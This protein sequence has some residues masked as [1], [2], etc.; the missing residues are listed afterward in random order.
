MRSPLHVSWSDLLLLLLLL[1]LATLTFAQYAPE[2]YPGGH[3]TLRNPYRS[4]AFDSTE[5]QN[6]AIQDLVCDHSLAPGWYRFKLNNKPAE[7]PTTCVEMNRCGTQ[8]PVWLSLKD[9]SLP[10]PGEVLQL[11]ACATWQFFHG[12][13]KDC[14]L[15]RIPITIRNCGDFLIYYLQPTQGCMGYC[16]Q[17]APTLPPRFCLPG[18]VEIN[19]RCK[20]VLP[21]LLS[22]PLISSELIG[23][24]VH[25]R[26]SFIPPPSNE[27]L[28]F[29][30]VWARHI[31]SS[32]K[33]EIR[34]ESTLKHFS[35]VEMDGLHFRLGETYSCSVS[36]FQVNVTSS[37]SSPRESEAFYAGL[38]FSVES[39]HIAENGEE[40]E[41]KVHST[42]P[43]SCYDVNQCGIP[44]VLGVHDSDGL[45]HEVPNVVVSTCQVLLR[46]T[47]CSE[48]SCGQASFFVT[49]VTDFTRDGNRISLISSLPENGAPQLWRSYIPKSLKVTV[50]DVPTSICYSLTDPHVITLDGR[51]YDNQQTGTF[52]LYRSLV[53]EFEV[54]SRQWDCGSRHHTVACSCGVAAREGNGVA[55]IDMCNGQLQE[56]RPKI[57]VKVLGGEHGNG[58]RLRVLDYHQGKKVT[59]IFPSG[60]FVRAD[61]GDWGMSL[62]IRAPSVD[63]GNTQGLC[64]TFDHNI[65]NDIHGYKGVHDDLHA[66]IEDWRI[67]PGESLF[68]KMPPG[69]RSEENRPFCRCQKGYSSFRGAAGN[70]ADPSILT[71]C[72]AQD[73]VDDTNLFPSL[74]TTLEYIKSPE[75]EGNI[76]NMS[77]SQYFVGRASHYNA[78]NDEDFRDDQRL[79]DDRMRRQTMFKM[80]PASQSI[81]QADL[82][83]LAYFF[84][85]DHL[86]KRRPEVQPRWPTPSGLSSGKALEVCHVVLSNST[87]G[88]VCR[89]LL[90]RRLEEAVNLCMLDLQLKDDLAW[91]DAMLPYLENECERRLLDNRAQ[92]DHGMLSHLGDVVKALQCPNYCNGNGECTEFGCQCHKSFSLYDCSVT[93]GQPVELSDLENGGLCDLRAFDC[94]KVRVFGLGFIKSDDLSCHATRLKYVNGIWI[95]RE[96]QKTKATFLSSKA[97]DCGIPSLSSAAVSTEDFMMDNQPYARWEIQVTNDGSQYSLPKVLTIYDGICQVCTASHSGTCELKDR[98]C[99]IDGMCFAEGHTNPGSPCLICDPNTSTFTWSFNQVNQPPTFHQPQGEVRTF[100]GENFVFQFAASDP[101]GSALL[102]Q[103]VNGPNGA[104]LS[105]AGLLIWKV[106]AFPNEEQHQSTFDFTLSDECN[107][108]DT[109]TVQIQVVPCGCQNGGTCVTDFTFPAGSGKYLC[110]CPNGKQ[111][112]HCHEDVDKCLSAPCRAGTC[113]NTVSG[114]RCNCPVGLTGATCEEDVD[115]CKW[116]P[117]FPGVQCFNSYGSYHC[118]PCPMGMKGNGTNCIVNMRPVTITSTLGSR[119]TVH[120]VKDTMLQNQTQFDQ[121]TLVTRIMAR[122]KLPEEP[123]PQH[124]TWRKASVIG[125]S[126]VSHSHTTSDTSKNT[127]SQTPEVVQVAPSQISN[128]NEKTSEIQISPKA[129][130]ATCNSRPCF[131]GVQCINKR[132]PHVGYVCGRCPPG[133]YGNGRICMKSAKAASEHLL[134]KTGQRRRFLHSSSKVS[135]PH[136]PALPSRG[137]IKH[138][139]V[140]LDTTLRQA[141][142][143]GGG[144]GNLRREVNTFDVVRSTVSAVSIAPTYSDNTRSSEGFLKPYVTVPKLSEQTAPSRVTPASPRL[145]PQSVLVTKAKQTTHPFINYIVSTRTKPWISLK[146]AQPLM[147]TFGTLSYSL[148]ETGSFADKEEATMTL[149]TPN[150]IPLVQKASSI[151]TWFSSGV[152]SKKNLVPCADRPCFP[153]VLCNASLDGSF[154][155]GHCPIGFTGDGK[156]CRAV[157]KHTCGQNMECAAPNICLCK[158]GYTGSDCKTAICDPVCVNGGTCIAPGVCECPIGFHGETCQEALCRLACENGGTCTG[159]QTCSCPYGFVGPRC[160]TMIC[161]RHCHNGGRCVSPDECKCQ[162]GWSGPLCETA[163]CTPF[164]L[165]GG[166]CIQPNT[167]ECPRSFYGAQCQNAI[168]TPPCKNGGRCMRNNVCSCPQGY[169]GRLCEQS[170]CEHMCINGGRCVRPN[171]CDCPSGWRGNR[172]DKPIC[173]QNCLN[174]AECVGPNTCQCAPGWHGMFCN[175]PHCQQKCS[176]GSR[177]VKPNFCACQSGLAGAPCKRKLSI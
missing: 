153:G 127:T 5:I 93:I 47:A 87:V 135:S 79:S 125:L 50:Q 34:Q 66:F 155:C 37:R 97:L 88:T 39:L 117:C 3:R 113:V 89:G 2:C 14:C 91:E 166:V 151:H 110:E 68:D 147:G 73:N 164:C 107:A 95:P 172:C 142:A 77:S 51:H 26:C 53:R 158:A 92:G 22:R 74:D 122:Y 175:I 24:S 144:G 116:T 57:T 28:G 38:K 4:I 76:L 154:H 27:P 35:L 123:Q 118:G 160:E 100:A 23:H 148:P 30:V 82:A 6:T 54:H 101:E 21:S 169:T 115:E 171:V 63:Y 133:L 161:S 94:H 15:F 128:T 44:L 129:A 67:A 31:S 157:C 106:P 165:N 36:T 55:I 62:S 83:H 84:P 138:L 139:S 60:A 131:P 40:H 71:D 111:G 145:I 173:E 132:P 32:M 103:L 121:R 69:L 10:R 25:L 64:G 48:G 177:C 119:T 13:T 134:Q 140:N 59:I 56:T 136:L 52:V 168:C 20:G 72:I 104:I 70:M 149:S 19:G 42:V 159:L 170:V 137:G 90:G 126:S 7:M 98:T 167:C 85:E 43:L 156:T 176:Y 49:A 29:R 78:H 150:H 96:K 130:A 141:P 80:E 41:V 124:T 61:V 58:R 18:E 65:N 12:S 108:Q 112:N 86:I 146:P 11:S 33:A 162:S 1:L 120:K 9:K 75:R 81:S 105:P 114:F 99:N 152:T 143:V 174:G 45:G 16:A 8:A 102:F 46:S 109:F 17:V 163:L